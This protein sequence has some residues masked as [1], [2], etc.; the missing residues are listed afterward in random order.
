MNTVIGLVRRNGKFLPCRPFCYITTHI[1]SPFVFDL[2]EV[3]M[4]WPM[5]KIFIIDKHMS[6]F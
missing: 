4:F 1:L 6:E 5:I 3:F 2:I